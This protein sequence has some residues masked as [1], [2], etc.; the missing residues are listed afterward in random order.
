ME[1]WLGT[2]TFQLPFYFQIKKIISSSVCTVFSTPMGLFL[3]LR[4]FFIPMMTMTN[5]LPFQTFIFFKVWFHIAYNNANDIT[6]I[7]KWTSQ[8]CVSFSQ[9]FSK[10]SPC[11]IPFPKSFALQLFFL[12]FW[13]SFAN[14]SYCNKLF[15]FRDYILSQFFFF[16]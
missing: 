6:S 8:L 15:N 1:I 16:I 11:F 12:A 7:L 14:G 9:L 4:E 10:T 13:L 5:N 2:P 3:L